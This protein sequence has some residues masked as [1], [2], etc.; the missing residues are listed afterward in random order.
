MKPI[1]LPDVR[2]INSA[3]RRYVHQ[4]LGHDLM[5]DGMVRLVLPFRDVRVNQYDLCDR[6]YE[7]LEVYE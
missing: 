6:A 2:G 5:Y 1:R 3:Q 7:E 4:V